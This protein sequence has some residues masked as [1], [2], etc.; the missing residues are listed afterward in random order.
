MVGHYSLK[1]RIVVR[2]HVLELG[3]SRGSK[4]AVLRAQGTVGGLWTG[5]GSW[6]A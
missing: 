6:E 2:I 1:V 5:T 4:K 3:I